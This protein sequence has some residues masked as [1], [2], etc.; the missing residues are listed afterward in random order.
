MSSSTERPSGAFRAELPAVSLLRKLTQLSRAVAQAASLDGILQLA[1][2][3]AAAILE[4]DQT[5]LMLV[6]DDGLAHVRASEGIDPAITLQLHTQLD[7][8]LIS[9]VE[10]ALVGRERRSFMAVPLIVQ[11]EVTGLIAV[12]RGGSAPWTP[13]EEAVLAAVADQSAAPIEIARLT[14]EVRQVRLIAENARLSESEREARQ[15]L[16]TERARLATVIDNMPVGVVL[17]EAPSGRVIF[18]NRAVVQISGLEEDQVDNIEAYGR[19]TGLHPDGRPYAP[20]EWPLARAV[21]EGETVTGEEIEVVRLDGSRMVLSMNAA[22]IRDQNGNIIAAVTAFQDVTHRRRVEQHLRQVQQMEAVGRLAG[23]MAHEANNQMSVVLS[24]SAFILKRTD[25]PDS[26]RKDV[27]SIKRAAERTAAVTAQLLAFGRRQIL[28]PQVID[29][30]QV[31]RDFCPVLRR[32]LGEDIRVEL[33]ASP[34]AALIKADQ[35]QIEQV[36]LNLTLNARDVMP[37]GGRLTFDIS[38][39]TLSQE[40]SSFKSDVTVKP[41]PYVL[42][43]VSDTGEGMDQTV[44]S[45]IFEPFFTTKPVGQGTGLG[46]STVY[47]IVK[48]SE[49]Y[50]WAY[51]EPGKGTAFKIYLPAEPAHV[52]GPT[53]KQPPTAGARAGEV[54]L[55][56]EDEEPGRTMILRLLQSE[57]YDVLEAQDGRHALEL[58]KARSGRLDLVITDVA[59]PIM[60]GR[61]LAGHLKALRPALPVL[62]ISGYTD[63]EMVRR[64]LIE[65]SSPFLSKP[66]TPEVLGAKVRSLLDQAVDGLH[67]HTVAPGKV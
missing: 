47:G 4:A 12:T 3:Q 42:L 52:T 19:L 43:T 49:G 48:Q 13:E 64:G 10:A 2:S 6:G 29:L 39:I 8:R 46:L 38:Q 37:Q 25:V 51:S 15:A 21:L 41:G 54:V 57:G 30:H 5:L 61:E 11:G 58:I 32:T 40:Y 35:G 66:F 53:V 33:R 1:A 31:V 50:V 27:E 26:V 7:E 62:F 56:V 63:D 18:R 17:A 67:P 22:P 24:A 28:R 44:L 34:G 9:R 59:M 65:P 45:R 23:G 55:I 36:L 60:N 14:E 20:T 16:E